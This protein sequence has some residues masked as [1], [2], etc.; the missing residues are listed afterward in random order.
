MKGIADEIE[1]EA[2]KIGHHVISRSID[3]QW[4]LLDFVD[5]VV[6]IFAQD[7]RMFY[8]LESLWG[9]AK[10]VEWK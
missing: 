6:H 4:I 7:A 1:D 2:S 8:D 5:V 10:T 3:E 9:D